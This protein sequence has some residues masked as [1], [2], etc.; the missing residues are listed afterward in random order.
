MNLQDLKP[1]ELPH[2][3]FPASLTVRYSWEQTGLATTSCSERKDYAPFRVGRRGWEPSP[4]YLADA[5]LLHKAQLVLRLWSGRRRLW[6]DGM[7]REVSLVA[8]KLAW[9]IGRMCRQ[10]HHHSPCWATECKSWAC[11]DWDGRWRCQEE[12]PCWL[13]AVD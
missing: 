4:T 7:E 2:C 6:L 10:Q 1:E 9:Q 3:D 5:L 13:M 12:I 11:R 8:P